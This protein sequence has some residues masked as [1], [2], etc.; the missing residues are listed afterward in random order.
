MAHIGTRKF[1][2]EQADTRLGRL[3]FQINRTMK[4][5]D[6]DSVH[7]L[8]VAI[9]RFSQALRVFKPYFRGKEVR[10][11]RREL[12]EM[13]DV[14]G[15]VRNSDIALNMISKS[16]ASDT[17]GVRPKFEKHRQDSERALVGLLKHWVDRKSSLKWRGTVAS[18][19]NTNSDA[20]EDPPIATTAQQLL[21]GMAQDF[22]DHGKEAG[23]QKA[24]PRELHQFRIALKK[25]RYTLELFTSVYGPPLN[26]SLERIRRAQ[27]LLGDINDCETV[28]SMLSQYKVANKSLSWLTKRRRRR[29]EKFQRYWTETFAAEGALRSWTA[30]LSRPG[31]SMREPRKPSSRAGGLGPQTARR[32]PVAVA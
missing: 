14:A 19:G 8:R 12:T 32:R 24:S 7:D 28:R 16:R 26:A 27:G 15:E 10:K 4:C 13:M 11:I 29:I 6:A 20:L 3:A 1:A 5:R 9:R 18:A 22:F 21:P 2:A 31:V 30:L 17:T 23:R 25:F